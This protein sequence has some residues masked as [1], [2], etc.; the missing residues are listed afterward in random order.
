MIYTNVN[1]H[2]CDDSGECACI[3]RSLL[4]IGKDPLWK[5]T[6]L[7]CVILCDDF[8]CA[9]MAATG[10]GAPDIDRLLSYLREYFAMLAS[11]LHP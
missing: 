10:T 5:E 1:A 6:G 8:N 7:L 2:G 9:R 11:A 4:T 3:G